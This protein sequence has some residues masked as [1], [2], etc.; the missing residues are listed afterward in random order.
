M[1]YKWYENHIIKWY[2]NGIT[3]IFPPLPHWDHYSP[4][5]LTD[6][7][8]PV[9]PGKIPTWFV[10]AKTGTAAQGFQDRRTVIVTHLALFT[11]QRC[12]KKGQIPPKSIYTYLYT[13]IYILI[14]Y[15]YTD[16]IYIMIIYIYNDNIYIMIIYI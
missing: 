10:S 5:D 2:I 11:K 6:W 9:D 13:L 1:V 3:I 16:N 15:I 4:L 7:T 14:I 8:H 12:V